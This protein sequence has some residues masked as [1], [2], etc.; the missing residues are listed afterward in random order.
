[1]SGPYK[2][3]F[4][5][6][7]MMD[8]TDRRCRAFHRILTRR[9]R[10]YTEMVTADAVVFGP[11]ERLIGFDAS[12]HPVA[13]QLGGADPARLAEAARIGVAFGYD[14][15]NLNC[16]CPSDRV[17]SGRFGACLMRE[18]SLVAECVA[19]MVAAVDVPVTVKCRIGVDEQEPREALFAFAEAVKAAGAAALVVH[20]RK[21]WLEG[22]S[23]KDNRS[24]P[25]LDYEIVHALKR[26]HADW[27]IILNGGL[28]DLN[29]ARAHLGHLDGIMLG[30]AAYQNPELL[31]A[32]DPE[33]FGEPSP[34]ADG[35]EAIEVFMAIIAHGLQRGERLHDYTR[36]LHG[37]FT[38]RPGARAYRQVL[39]TE[40]VK[41]GV[42][43]AVLRDAVSR[44]EREQRLVAAAE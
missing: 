35:F 19:A 31:I 15:M 38:G 43:L 37:M 30:R 27:P 34:V 4:C 33:L 29:A 42:G 12:E 25:P 16:G 6:A 7:P 21:A 40:A 36:H 26:A 5:V 41:R 28:A 14:E 3:R 17:Q 10:L 2:A 9:A 20:A 22:L 11:R 44:V 23:P 32:V 13:L 24:I 39:A 8:W 18:P 1:M